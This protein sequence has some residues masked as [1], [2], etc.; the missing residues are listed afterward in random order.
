VDR[1]LGSRR[2]TVHSNGDEAAAAYVLAVR[3]SFDALVGTAAQMSAALLAAA[4]EVRDHSIAEGLLRSARASHAEA[5]DQLRN[6]SVPASASHHYRHLERASALIGCAISD[7]D[8]TLA[9][10][11]ADVEP[12]V[13]RLRRGW[14][15]LNHATAALP[16]LSVLNLGHCCALHVF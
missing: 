7:A 14:I 10:R 4:T 15:E 9:R 2:A 16:G 5:V 8:A 3:P 1:Y 13:S 11:G 6:A 12:I